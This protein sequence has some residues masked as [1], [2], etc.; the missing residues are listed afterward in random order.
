MLARMPQSP[1]LPEHHASPRAATT[2]SLAILSSSPITYGQSAMPTLST[3]APMPTTRPK[4]TLDT[5]GSSSI[6]GKASTS[7]RLET[8]SATSPTVRNTFQNR[9]E[10]VQ[11]SKLSGTKRPALTPLSTT[12]SPG[13]R[14]RPTPLRTELPGEDDVPDLISSSAVSSSSISTLDSLSADVPYMLAYN[15]TSILCNGPIPRTRSSRS[16]YARPRPV[17]PAAKKVAFRM[18]LTEEVKNIRY[19]MAHSDVETP[20]PSITTSCAAEVDGDVEEGQPSTATVEQGA[21]AG[22]PLPGIQSQTGEK[23]ESSDEE[24]SDTCP[25]TPVAG[26]RKKSRA[27]RWTLGPVNA[28][29]NQ[30]HID[31]AG[32]GKEKSEVT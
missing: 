2:M 31:K 16:P 19:T 12:V 6:F 17:F 13:A 30:E 10:V 29:P 22:R 26:R 7:L 1:A 25:A 27:W 3:P 5:H 23:R 24:D 32:I 15:I 8:L 18:P 14:R 11:Q 28:D 9:Y 21:K 20:L 4:L